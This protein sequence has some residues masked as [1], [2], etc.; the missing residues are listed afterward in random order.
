MTSIDNDL[1][2][3]EN[4]IARAN[5]VPR[6]SLPAADS[7]R[8]RQVLG[9]VLAAPASAPNRVQP[10]RLPLWL[11]QS[12][13]AQLGIA[14]GAIAVIAAVTV[15][16]LLPGSTSA[17]PQTGN[18]AATEVLIGLA[19][20]AAKQPAVRPPGRGQYQYTDS[21]SR[22]AAEYVYRHPFSLTFLQTRQIWI[23]WNGSGRLA[24]ATSH[25]R[26]MTPH[27]RAAWIADGRPHLAGTGTSD[28]RFGHHGLS[29][30]PVNEWK[31]PTNPT[32]LGAL[33]RKRAIEGGPP[34]PAED[35][36]QVGDLL[37]ETDAPS[38]LRAALFKVAA[39]IPGVWILGRT[40]DRLGRTGIVVAYVDRP[41]T[42]KYRGM[43]GLDELIF[44]PKTSALLDEQTVLVNTKAH[45]RKITTWTAYVATGVV[46]SVT[47]VAPPYLRTSAGIKP[48]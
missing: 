8:A 43:Y 11:S 30:G 14:A 17:N 1:D 37:R 10:G 22:G 31:L 27:D 16:Q 40:T 6:E 9:T 46:N 33:L 15:S 19:G 45:T 23:G 3:V 42:G 39:S 41:R 35:F 44:A 34:G 29:D 13:A 7:P 5:P 26:F 32:K 12:R 4:D 21:I 36:V 24:E 20:V 38:A 2:R 47:A 28:Q 48:E 25:P 18:H